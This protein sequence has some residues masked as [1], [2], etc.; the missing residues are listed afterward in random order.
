MWPKLPA[1]HKHHFAAAAPARREFS[2]GNHGL[3]AADASRLLVRP[4]RAYNGTLRSSGPRSRKM[5]VANPRRSKDRWLILAGLVIIGVA[6]VALIVAS[7]QDATSLKRPLRGFSIPSRS[8]EPTLRIGDYMFADM[9]AYDTDA[10]TRGDVVVYLLPRDMTTIYTHRIVGLP[11]ETM[12]M[13]SGVLHIDGKAVPTVDAGPYT[14]TPEHASEKPSEGRL[15]RETLPNGVSVL[16]L[17]M[18]P[19]GFYDNTQG[20]P[21]PQGHYFVMGDN[22]DN[23]SDSRVLSQV[24]YVPRANVIGRAAWIYWSHEWSRIGTVPK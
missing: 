21:V 20:Y 22:R 3:I 8:M 19:N 1:R 13:K 16:T 14:L 12:Q 17:D 7:P 11:G 2:F 4:P 23:S 24:G 18:V 6:L 15:K 9:R 10:P 5:S